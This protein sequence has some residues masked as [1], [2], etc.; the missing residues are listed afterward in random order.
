MRVSQLLRE[1]YAETAR[2]RKD[3]SNRLRKVAVNTF[4]LYVMITVKHF[5]DLDV[6]QGAV[7][8]VIRVSELAKKLPRDAEAEAT[9]TQVH[10]KIALRHCYIAQPLFEELDD[11]Y[12][13]V[14][15]QIREND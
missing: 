9:E 8:L 11:A 4:I 12:D 5:R 14:L 3:V 13:K 6:Y 10:L 7:D 15:A 1:K 2:R